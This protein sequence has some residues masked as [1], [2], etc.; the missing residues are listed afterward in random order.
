MTGPLTAAQRRAVLESDPDTGRISAR[1]QTCAALVRMGLAVRYGRV[2]DHYLTRDGLRLREELSRSVR[3]DP[4]P[5][6]PP[7]AA[8]P[9]PP[10]GFAAD[11]GNRPRAVSRPGRAAQVAAAWAGLVEIRRVLQD[12]DTSRPAPWERERLVHAVALAL[13]AAGRTPSA[14]DADGRR[15]AAGYSVAPAAQDGVAEVS[16]HGH[17]SVPGSAAEALA[18]YQGVLERCGWQC[19]LHRDRTGRSFL[20]VSPRRA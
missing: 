12:G 11:D 14:L 19:T 8:R 1:E 15:A 9:E 16:W 13:E 6:G 4:A 2:G 20:L 10:G 7:I 17:G 3:P 18:S 5:V